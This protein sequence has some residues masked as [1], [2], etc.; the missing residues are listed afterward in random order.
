[1]F[2]CNTYSVVRGDQ[3]GKGKANR[4]HQVNNYPDK[5]SD[6]QAHSKKFLLD[7]NQQRGNFQPS[8]KDVDSQSTKG[9]SLFFM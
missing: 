5:D 1:M 6:N 9:I 7:Q 2:N 8:S 4:A 3:Y